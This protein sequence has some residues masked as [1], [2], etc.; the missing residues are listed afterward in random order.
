MLYSLRLRYVHVMK[1]VGKLGR[2]CQVCKSEYRGEIETLLKRNVA[3]PDIAR[4]F[5]KVAGAIRE[6]NF[7]M[8]LHRHVQKKHP[9]RFLDQS[10]IEPSEIQ[11]SEDGSP[12]LEGYAQK[13]LDTAFRDPTMFSGN[14]ISHNAVIAA[15]RAVLEKEKIKNQGDALKMSMIQFLRGQG[16]IPKGEVIDAELIESNTD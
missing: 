16:M 1:H 8:A 11:K 14:K 12:T 5:W 10:P 7:Y 15:Q 6:V 13:L 3:I 2:A 9:F 4:K